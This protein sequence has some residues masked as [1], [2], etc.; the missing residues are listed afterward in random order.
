MKKWLI[1]A[2]GIV[3]FG[4]LAWAV[5]PEKPEP[6]E[7]YDLGITMTVENLTPTGCT[8]KVTQSGGEITGEV[9]CGCD[10][11]VEQ[12]NDGQWVSLGNDFDW[13]AE[14]Y[15][16]TGHTEAF[17]LNWEHMYGTL[18]EGTYRVGK[19]IHSRLEAGKPIDQRYYTEPFTIQ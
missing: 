17:V 7:S 16:L 6:P 15:T 18:P 5:T 4:L 10:F 11:W 2:L 1:F 13:T 19:L 14:G 8:L 3:C 9:S 12:Q